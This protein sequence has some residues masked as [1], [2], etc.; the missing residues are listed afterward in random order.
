MII[1]TDLLKMP[2]DEGAKIAAKRLVESLKGCENVYV[3]SLNSKDKLAIADASFKI[4]KL[5][6]ENSFYS[7]IKAQSSDTIIYIPSGSATIFSIIRSKLLNIFTSKEVYLVALQ[8]IKY[9]LVTWLLLKTIRPKLMITPSRKTAQHFNELKIPCVSLPLGVDNA[10]YFEF[11]PDRKRLVREKYNIGPEEIVLLHVGHIQHSRNLDWLIEVKRKHAEFVIIVVG[12]T[13][14]EDDK[15]LYTELVNQGITVIRR[16]ITSMVDIYNLAN[17]YIFPVLRQDGAIE[18]PLSVL[19]AMA[20]NL[21]II[22]TR[23]GSL[24]DTFKEDEDFYYVYSS[25]EI[26]SIIKERKKISCNN[27]E[28]IRPFSWNIIAEKLINVVED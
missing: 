1:L 4:N 9:S 17:Y 7:A 19:E 20:C 23:F 27:R 24:P 11:N 3:I 6:I 14:N 8:P 13:Y 12:S 25:T 28:K 18:T 5:L 15:A 10:Q 22:T 21:P 2:F 26:L 16:Y